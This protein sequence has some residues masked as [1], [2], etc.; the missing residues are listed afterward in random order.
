MANPFDQFDAAGPVTSAAP[1]A[2]GN[3]FDQ[4]D[5]SKPAAAGADFDRLVSAIRARESG[6]KA[7]AVSPQGAKG[8][9]QIMPGTFKDFALPGESFDNEEH[10]TAAALR[11]LKADFE[12]YGGDPAKTAAAYLGGRGAVLA[13]GTLRDDVKDALGTNPRAY[14]Q[15]VVQRMGGTSTGSRIR[16][17]EP[18]FG[19][20]TLL[21]GQDP[22][23]P[24]G[25]VTTGDFVK[26]LV[27]GAASGLGAIAQGGGEL[28]ARGINA[29]A[30]TDLRAVNPLQGAVDW[31]E[32]SKSPAAKK[33]VADSEIS[34]NLFEPA[35]WEFGK[36]PNIRGL[37][38]QGIN[39]IGQF[40]PNL[41]IALITGGASLPTQL[42]IG[43]T[44]G[45]LQALGA[46]AGEERDRFMKMTPEQLQTDSALY[47]ELLAKGIDPETAKGAVA[48]AAALGGGLGNAIPSAAEGAFENFLVGALTRGKVKL[49][50]FGAGIAGRIGTGLVGGAAVGGTQEAAEKVAQNLGVNLAAGT[51]R[52]AGEG[53]LQD[54]VMGALGEGTLGGAAGAFSRPL[55]AAP[56]DE[57]AAP[58][59]VAGRAAQAVVAAAMAGAPI[60]PVTATP[61]PVPAASATAPAPGEPAAALDATQAAPPSPYDTRIAGI[62]QVLQTPGWLAA[63]AERDP[64]T[65]DELLH[66]F[67]LARN[68]KTEDRLRKSLLEQIEQ[69]I[70][71][72]GNVLYQPNFVPGTPTPPSTAVAAPAATAV[73][74]VIP[75]QPADNA[76]PGESRRV[77]EELPGP[78]NRRLLPGERGDGFV[79]D[80]QGEARPAWAGDMA[81]P[82]LPSP[83]G[84]DFVAGA[85]GTG[86][87]T[88][89]QNSGLANRQAEAKAAADAAA[90]GLTDDVRRAQARRNQI[91]PGDITRSDGTAFAS[92][93]S[94]NR[95]R[96]RNIAPEWVLTPVREGFVWRRPAP[97]PAAS[98]S[99]PDA[100]PQPPGDVSQSAPAGSQAPATSTSTTLDD[101]EAAIAEGRRDATL[102]DGRDIA[103]F[104]EAAKAR[105]WKDDG[106][107]VVSRDGWQIWAR[108][109]G[110]DA[111][112]IVQWS[113][114]PTD[115]NPV[116]KKSEKKDT[117]PAA[118]P[119][120]LTIDDVPPA[121]LKRVTVTVEQLHGNEVKAVEV[122]AL[123]AIK[124]LD[125]EISAYQK[126]LD[127]VRGA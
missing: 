82:A 127:C 40:A 26:S 124:D 58:K 92:E 1:A 12:Y 76:I 101:A 27:S 55:D 87:P 98:A 19:E 21:P 7:D 16:A 39:T 117:A 69:R 54:F 45:G 34:G 18:A 112:P 75:A 9:M 37:A 107:G 62:Q 56:A 71:E 59:G 125:E 68:P 93:G 24:V 10:R 102:L 110:A 32:N 51:T 103:A 15:Q 65:K 25:S 80:S 43:A 13:D 115:G 94:A 108:S 91:L 2:S 66:A 77:T 111:A 5:A 48:E 105:G 95:A 28:V 36:D 78:P 8:S 106:K 4:F 49:P 46:S 17:K 6:G 41:A 22:P 89:M 38:L 104:I 42:S 33:A 60:A 11:K 31:L 57:P 99:Q 85:S 81:R 118:A 86:T 44:V 47:R 67:A 114:K 61:G 72:L 74:P 70:A 20:L 53:T 3:P 52:A 126:L 121:V 14:A 64:E 122:S 83:S 88:A 63:V 96:R 123:E 116:S 120:V 35:S 113:K 23:K 73:G 30:G 109:Q 84:V 119:K 100:A 90:I 50:S 79:V 29:V 97:Q